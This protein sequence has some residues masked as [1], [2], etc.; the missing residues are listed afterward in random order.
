MHV[1]MSSIVENE[2]ETLGIF[3]VIIYRIVYNVQ[4]NRCS[5]MM[6]F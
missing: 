6:N 1:W 5:I 2:V 4:V 3:C